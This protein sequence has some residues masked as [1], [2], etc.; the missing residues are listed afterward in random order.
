M[1]MPTYFKVHTD[2]LK[3][4]L[5]PIYEELAPVKHGRWVADDKFENGKSSIFHCS[6]C[7]YTRATSVTYT[8]EQLAKDDPYCKKCG[9]KMDGEEKRT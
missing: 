7:H 3:F 4:G 8:V 9:A 2:G 5:Q 6:E 1:K